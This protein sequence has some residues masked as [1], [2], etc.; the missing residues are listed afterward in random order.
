[1]T[2]EQLAGLQRNHL[3]KRLFLVLWRTIRGGTARTLWTC[4]RSTSSF[5]QLEEQGILFGAGPLRAEGESNAAPP[6]GMRSCAPR[7]LPRRINP[8]RR[9]V[10]EKRLPHVP[11]ACVDPQRRKLFRAAPVRTALRSR[12]NLLVGAASSFDVK[13]TRAASQEVL[14][15]VNRPASPRDFAFFQDST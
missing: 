7:A 13:Y 4:C 5:H 11:A 2:A 1:M 15:P 3:G 14:P 10:H 9:T 8:R 12:L 6:S